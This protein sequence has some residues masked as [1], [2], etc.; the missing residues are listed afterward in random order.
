[1]K[2][3]LKFSQFSLA[4]YKFLVLP[5]VKNFELSEAWNR[6]SNF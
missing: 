4:V 5:T 2:A 3:Q 6:Q 1:M